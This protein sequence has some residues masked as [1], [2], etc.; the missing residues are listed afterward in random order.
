MMRQ[1]KSLL[2][3]TNDVFLWGKA[4][5]QNG[6]AKCYFFLIERIKDLLPFPPRFHQSGFSEYTQM[7]GDRRLGDA[8]PFDHVIH[9]KPMAAQQAHYLLASSVSHR[10]GKYY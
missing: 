10:L 5:H 3:T 8:D 6:T 4:L 1:K 7:V 9:A 2:F